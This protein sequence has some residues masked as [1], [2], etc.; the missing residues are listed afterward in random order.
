MRNFASTKN[1]RQEQ[2][3]RG[4][5]AGADRRSYSIS[6]LVLALN[7][8]ALV[9]RVARETVATAERMLSDYEVILIDDGSTD[10]TGSIMD[11]LAS[12]LPNTGV[13]HNGANLGFGASYMRGVAAARGDYIM[14]LCGDDGLP[15]S[16][17]PVIIEK[18]GTA[19]IVIPYMRNLKEIK[20]P[21]RYFISRGYTILLNLLFGHRLRYYNGL[22]VHRR[23][24]LDRI[25]VKSSGFGFQGEILIKLLKSGCSY[26]EV[27]VDGAAKPQQ[28]SV[29]LRPTNVLNV[30]RTCF[31]LV[32]EL[33]GFK[34]S[35]LR[36][37]TD[38]TER[39]N[40]LL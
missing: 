39:R 37:T 34:G 9:E 29:L 8:E 22:S 13:I 15:T 6:I 24:F 25:T 2:I 31:F 4:I 38:E 7:E 35:A 3:F 33:Y 26:V 40:L 27:G 20:T 17:L 1:R 11:R 18:I 10:R 36:A 19:D 5:V 14:L 30:L 23:S 28:R 12:E 21:L 16:N 32:V